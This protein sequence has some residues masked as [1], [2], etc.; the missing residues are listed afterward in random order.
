MLVT[1]D[2]EL[3]SNPELA[4]TYA[5]MR[6]EGCH[7]FYNGS[8]A[9]KIFASGWAASVGL[10]LTQ[11]DFSAHRGEWIHENRSAG[12]RL[13]NTTYKG[14]YRVFELPPNPGGLATLEM[15]NVTP[16]AQSVCAC[17]CPP[18]IPQL[19]LIYPSLI[20]L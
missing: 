4:E 5:A 10:P 20:D 2:G 3:F 17:D 8:V 18:D 15:L 1:T 13:L 11:E 6:D 7:A 19:T 9:R 14:R 12:Y 16:L